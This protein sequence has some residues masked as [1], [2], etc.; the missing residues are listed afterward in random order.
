MAIR[1]LAELRADQ[2]RLLEAYRSSLQVTDDSA[3][4]A[5]RDP[6]R[7]GAAVQTVGKVTAVVTSDATY[8]AHLVCQPQVFDGVPPVA[9]DAAKPTA[10]A[11]PTPNRVVG[12]YAVGDF[13]LLTPTRGAL[14]AAVLG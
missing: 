3:S 8:G 10:V 1:S 2:A 6:G 11:Y 7:V 5:T 12:D 4:M 9:V 13:V 14:L